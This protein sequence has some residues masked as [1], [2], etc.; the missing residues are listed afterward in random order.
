MTE[1][2]TWPQIACRV[3][4][5]SKC[6]LY[7]CRPHCALE[8]YIWLYL[9]VHFQGVVFLLFLSTW[10]EWRFC[11]LILSWK[12]VRWIDKIFGDVLCKWTVEYN[13][14]TAE[15]ATEWVVAGEIQTGRTNLKNC[16]WVCPASWFSSLMYHSFHLLSDTNLLVWP[17]SKRLCLSVSL[18]PLC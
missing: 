11:N 12:N 18:P 5:P 6:V 9:L 7:L 8:N 13:F 1:D 16:T 15:T 4:L 3:S 2:I 10:F 14:L 17:E